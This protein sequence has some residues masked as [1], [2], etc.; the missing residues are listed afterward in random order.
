MIE[1]K[2]ITDHEGA[3][4]SGFKVQ[5][6]RNWRH[7]GVGPAYSKIGRAVRYDRAELIAFIE[8]RKVTPDVFKNEKT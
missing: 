7:R 4:L 2:Y 8:T 6:L 3:A 5:T 1:K